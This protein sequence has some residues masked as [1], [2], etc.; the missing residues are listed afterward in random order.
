MTA[1]VTQAAP[2]WYAA[3]ANALPAQPSLRA[4]ERADV[5]VLGAGITGLSTAIELAERGYSVI[6]LEAE[7]IGWGASGRSGGQMIFGYG[8]EQHTLRN[9]V[10]AD[11]ARKLFDWSR[12][13]LRLI[14]ERVA[15]YRIDCDL[16]AGHAHAAIK[17]RQV[18]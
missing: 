11:D 12:E 7:T 16:Q 4:S 18:E 9:L 10:G 8:C 14:G 1:A 2:S 13:G 3:S 15:K 17:P 5:V 6:V